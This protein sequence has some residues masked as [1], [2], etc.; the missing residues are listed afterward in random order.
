MSSAPLTVV[1]N[2][3]PTPP[4]AAV[5]T[6]FPRYWHYQ[7]A[8]DVPARI[9]KTQAD[10]DALGSDWGPWPWTAE[11]VNRQHAPEPEGA[12]D[13]EPAGDEFPHYVYHQLTKNV[14]PRIVNSPAEA[15]ALGAEWGNLPWSETRFELLERKDRLEKAIAAAGLPEVPAPAAEPPSPA[16]KE[17]GVAEQEAKW[18]EET[19]I[20]EAKAAEAAA[21]PALAPPIK[22]V[23]P[24]APPKPGA[25]IPVKKAA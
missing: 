23:A 24:V 3:I 6:E 25:A 20:G 18:A 2:R 11:T 22:L 14:P 15:A 7:G 19:K 4:A 1:P 13:G 8:K 16:P 5:L 17:P 21:K 9:V 10:V 12:P